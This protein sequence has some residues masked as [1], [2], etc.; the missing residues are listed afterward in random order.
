MCIFIRI[1]K[2]VRGVVET[3]LLVVKIVDRKIL[4]KTKVKIIFRNIYKNIDK[5]NS[6]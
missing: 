1:R 5:I 4:K 2:K 3:A 6:V